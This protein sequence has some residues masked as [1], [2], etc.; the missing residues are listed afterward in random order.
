LKKGRRKVG[1]AEVKVERAKVEA[2][3]ALFQAFGKASSL[4][5]REGDGMIVS[6]YYAPK[7][8]L[9]VNGVMVSKAIISYKGAYG[10]EALNVAVKE[11]TEGGGWRAGKLSANGYPRYLVMQSA[12]KQNGKTKTTK[13]DDGAQELLAAMSTKPVKVDKALVKVRAVIAANTPQ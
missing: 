10:N 8:P 3:K 6:P 4:E 11:L 12:G 5:A 9:S 7:E 2:F 1:K 13:V